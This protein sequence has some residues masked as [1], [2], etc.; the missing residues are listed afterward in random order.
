MSPG[1]RC[2]VIAAEVTDTV[3]NGDGYPDLGFGKLL[4]LEGYEL[5]RLRVQ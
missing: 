1:V 5:A 3:G 4:G 2:F